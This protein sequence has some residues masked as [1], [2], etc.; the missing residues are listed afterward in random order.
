MTTQQRSS[1]A[2]R[3]TV[4]IRSCSIRTLVYTK[5]RVLLPNMASWQLGWTAVD[6]EDGGIEKGK[7]LDLV[8]KKAKPLGQELI[9][10]GQELMCR[11]AVYGEFEREY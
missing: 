5:R 11:W 6:G 9:S 7:R 1:S 4:I 2:G 10:M 8:S 3:A